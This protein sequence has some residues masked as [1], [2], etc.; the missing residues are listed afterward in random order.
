MNISIP[1]TTRYALA[2]YKVSWGARANEGGEFL[3]DR[4]LRSE[5]PSGPRGGP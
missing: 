1:L 3:I 4:V 5:D 2:L